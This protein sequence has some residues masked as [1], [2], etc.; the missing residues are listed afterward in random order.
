MKF[1]INKTLKLSL[2][3]LI[4]ILVSIISFIG[5]YVLDKGRMVNIV[6]NYQLGMDLGGSRRIELAVNTSKQTIKYDKD[7]KEIASNDTTTTV[8]R[9]EE[10]SVNEENVLTSDNY[11]SS[12]NILENRL[13]TMAINDY[14]IRLNETNGNIT[15]NIPENE[16][17]D[18]I[19]SQ[20]GYQGKFEIIDND[21]KEVLM[22]NEH[23]KSVKAGYGQSQ[24]GATTIF[25]NIE[26]NKEGAEKFK[27]ITNTYREVKQQNQETGEEET[28]KKQIALNIDG[29][30]ILATY[31]DEEISNGILQLSV[32][33]SSANATAEELQESLTK[34]NNLAALLNNG[35]MPVV[36]QINQNQYIASEITNQN[37]AIFTSL[38]IIVTTAL[39]IYAII[40]YKEKGILGGISLIGYIAILTLVLRYTNVVITINGIIALVLSTILNYILILKLL[41]SEKETYKKEILKFILTLVPVF[42][43]AVVFTFNNWLPIFSFGMIMFWGVAISLIYNL[44]ITRALLG[45]VKN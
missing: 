2:T 14:E 45:S 22:T 16:N 13:K 35:K 11:K 15:I 10:R 41:N 31:F 33:T 17:T 26:F 19:V 44:T 12:K 39:I 25:V 4:I 28:V 36:Y 34:A 24:T 40:K 21:T 30:A 7:G 20:I 38:S 27:N 37:I 32:G 3:I 23:L 9:Q 5:I 6:N 43:I 8:E 42:I 18:I 1:Q 29:S